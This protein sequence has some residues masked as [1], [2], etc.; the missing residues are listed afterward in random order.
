M[1]DIVFHMWY[2][3]SFINMYLNTYNETLTPF[4]EIMSC[5]TEPSDEEIFKLNGLP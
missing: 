1:I 3:L 2:H 5:S 4:I